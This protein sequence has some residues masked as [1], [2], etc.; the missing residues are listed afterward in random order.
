MRRALT[1]G[2]W[3]AL[4][5]AAVLAAPHLAHA[6]LVATPSDPLGPLALIGLGQA[7]DT[8][9]GFVT[10][11]G[12][13]QTAWTIPQGDSLQVRNTAIGTRILLLGAW[14]QN[15][16]AGIARIRSP[17][18]HDNVQGIR[19]RVTVAD[20]FPI[21]ARP[22]PQKLV[23]QDLL[24]VDQSGS[25]VGGQIESGSMLIWYDDLPG[26]A[27]RFISYDDVQKRGIDLM[28]QDNAIAFGAGGGYTGGQAINTTFDNWIAN[29]DYALIGYQVAT[30]CCTVSWRGADSSNLRVSGPGFVT[31]REYTDEWFLR[32]AQW[33]TLPCIP[34]FSSA[35]KGAV[36]IDGVQSQAGTAVAVTSIF[37]RLAPA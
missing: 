13:A 6:Q 26:A 22:I 17:K 30:Q 27:G 2:T 25:G 29:T 32:L 11:P 4:I 1:I 16:V 21:I 37:V 19:T 35:N 10:A 33:Y 36:T 3:L 28:Y 9:S 23:P 7:L 8:V 15:Q 31:G 20:T 18:L 34:I 12:G 24:T 5:L 14:F